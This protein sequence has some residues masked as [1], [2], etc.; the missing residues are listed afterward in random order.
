V[1]D[2]WG[3]TKWKWNHF[4]DS[5]CQ[6]IFV[7]CL[8]PGN[9]GNVKGCILSTDNGGRMN[10]KDTSRWQS[11]LVPTELFRLK[12]KAPKLPRKRSFF[13]PSLRQIFIRS[14]WVTSL[15]VYRGRLGARETMSKLNSLHIFTLFPQFHK[16]LPQL[17]QASV[18]QM[19]S[20]QSSSYHFTNPSK[21]IIL[22]TRPQSKHQ[23][24]HSFV[25][26]AIFVL[27]GKW[28]I[29]SQPQSQDHCK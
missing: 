21:N 22:T 23:G 11:S 14:Y 13:W 10:W 12:T 3:L 6:N 2:L 4:I 27:W 29:L 1:V 9:D 7:V 26:K 19:L 15:L 24:A 5:E 8:F 16:F 18:L 25:H 17:S 28:P 20:S